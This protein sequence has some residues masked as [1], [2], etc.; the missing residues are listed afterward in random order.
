MV[1]LI[2]SS[3]SNYLILK[4]FFM[5][6]DNLRNR[7]SIRKF[8]ERKIDYKIIEELKEVLLRSTSSRGINPWEFYITDDKVKLQQL[9]RSKQHGSTLIGEAALAVVISADSSKSDVWVEDCS[10]ASILLQ[11]AAEER[12]LGTC[13]VQIRE[14]KHTDSITSTDYVKE[15]LGITNNDI[16]ICSI[17]ALG[18]PNEEKEPHSY[19]DLQFEKIHNF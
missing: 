10:I 13:W 17:I 15:L 7:R 16:K 12:G 1:S 6:I 9:S 14:R 18:Y 8:K 3:L 2:S 4:Y 11:M 19:N 5:I